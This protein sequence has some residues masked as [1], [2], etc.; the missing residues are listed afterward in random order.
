LHLR[1]LAPVLAVWRPRL[2]VLQPTP[3]CNIDCDYCYLGNRD[4]R[5]LMASAVVDAVREKLFSRLAP[6][7]APTIVWHGGEPTVAP[8]SWFNYADRTLRAAAPAGATFAIQT[9]GIAISDAWIDFLR[10]NPTRIGLSIDGPQRF[11]DARRKTRAK[12][13]TWSLVMDNL[14]RL[15]SAGLPP[16]VISVLGPECLSAADEFYRF[17]RDNNIDQVR[18][19]I[20]EAIGANGVSSFEGADH[21]PALV[22][23]LRRILSTA[24]S[25]AYPLHV[26]DIERIAHVLGGDGTNRNEQVEAW[27]V[28]A[29][30]ANGDVTSFSP[31]FME[32]R[33]SEHNDFC[34]GN[35]LRD[36][37]EDLQENEFLRRT[38]VEIR[39]GIAICRETCRY[40][41]VCGGGSPS[42]K[43]FE[44]RSLACGE[45]LFCRLSIQAAADA[46]VEFLQDCS[47]PPANGDDLLAL[48][49]SS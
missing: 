30:A 35:I 29:V 33:S 47:L 23:F 27:D 45:T 32:L 14:R 13:P 24:F 25:E 41:D 28:I 37:F 16:H 22:A 15:Q 31:E 44:H 46:L 3:Y 5:R 42:N 49:K 18:F 34:F 10:Y 6:D 19:S 4:D 17:Y 2:I 40:F 38:A 20:D 26:H 11:H 39:S 12:N 21:K 9:N 1:V 43:M 48:V 36:N 7:S 8:I